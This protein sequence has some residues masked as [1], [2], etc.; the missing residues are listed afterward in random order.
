MVVKRSYSGKDVEMLI[1]TDTIMDSAIAHQEF[2]ESKRTIWKDPFFKDIKTEIETA[3]Q[4]HLGQ[5]NARDLRAA[6]IAVNRIQTPAL[7]DLAEFKIQIESD[8]KNDT[9]QK[10]EILTTLG[11]KSYN[12]DAKRKDQEALI[13][14]LFQFRTNATP[15]LIEIV[16]NKGTA[17]EIFDKITSYADELKN[18]NV[19]QEGKKGSRKE[20]TQEAIIDF[21]NVYNKVIAVAKIAANFFKENQAVKEQFSYAKVKNNLNNIREKKDPNT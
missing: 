3:I 7:F 4:R 15:E 5:D 10:N 16:T 6:T 20:V 14:L 1:A 8:F 9:T 11:F 12:A 21:N 19:L 13:N 2:L 17:P 18:A